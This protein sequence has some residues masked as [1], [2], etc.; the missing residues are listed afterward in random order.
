MPAPPP[1]H[2]RR[3]PWALWCS[4]QCGTDLAHL[5]KI[6]FTKQ[7]SQKSH[8]GAYKLWQCEKHTEE[9]MSHTHT[10]IH[11]GVCSCV[12]V[13]DLLSLLLRALVCVI[14]HVHYRRISNV[15]HGRW[16]WGGRQGELT[17]PQVEGD[18]GSNR[19]R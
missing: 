18:I 10:Q 2:L 17:P 15:A 1:T 13:I 4:M 7:T 5:P 3:G 8:W 11:N 6:R 19:L 9:A 16:R 12:S 14:N